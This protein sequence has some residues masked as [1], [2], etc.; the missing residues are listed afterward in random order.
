MPTGRVE[1]LAPSPEL[2]KPEWID[3]VN[4]AWR[5]SIEGIVETGRLL[6]L[7][8]ASMPPAEFDALVPR[9]FGFWRAWLE[10]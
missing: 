3:Q 2:N 6:L 7:G 9:E 8:H 10:S 4:V 1:V 5:K